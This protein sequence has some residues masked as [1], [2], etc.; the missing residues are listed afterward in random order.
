MRFSFHKDCTSFVTSRRVVATDTLRELREEHP[1]FLALAALLVAFHLAYPAVDWWLRAADIAPQFRFWDFGA[2]SGAVERWQAGESLYVRND[3][4]GYHGSYLYPPVVVLLFVPFVAFVPTEW[5]TVV[6]VLVSL[7]LLWV[8]VVAVVETL[9]GRRSW[10]ERVGLLWLLLGFQP[11]LFGLKM[12]QTAAFMTGLLCVAFVALDR[13]DRAGY[14]SGAATA[15]VGVVKFAYAPVGAHLLADRRRFVGAVAVGTGLIAAS[16]A[17]FGIASHREY[18][19]VLAWGVTQ[20]GVARSPALWLP[21]YYRPLG[22]VDGALWL[23]VAA[24]LAVAG[25]ALC[26]RDADR[27]V[28]ALGIAAFPLVTPLAY[29]YYFVALV[30]AA[31]ILIVGELAR[32]GYPAVPA[33]GLGL[34]SVHAYGLLGLVTLLSSTPVATYPSLYFLAQPGLWGNLLLVGTA[35]VWVGERVTWP[36]NLSILRREEA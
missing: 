5:A 10:T 2:Y 18:L 34:V 36:A 22:L 1:G 24:S 29:T 21:A 15:V 23:R 12:G 28:F 35:A 25:Y 19:D 32:D 30:P 26:A 6:W 31:A 4:G 13:G 11:L 17:L 7:A 16:L 27:A 33:L 20:G 8:G 3:D 9:V 14:L